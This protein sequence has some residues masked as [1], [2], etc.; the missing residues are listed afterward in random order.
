MMQI[1]GPGA[2]ILNRDIVPVAVQHVS[3]CPSLDSPRHTVLN[4]YDVID[5]HLLL[6]VARSA[7]CAFL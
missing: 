4:K 5:A 3:S 2:R 1:D 7:R 6:R